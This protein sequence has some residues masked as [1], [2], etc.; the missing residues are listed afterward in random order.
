MARANAL[1]NQLGLHYGI[2]NFWISCIVQ[3]GLLQ[4]ALL[5]TALGAFLTK[6]LR[7]ADR[8]AFAILAL[9]MVIAAS[10]VSF[11][12]KNIQLAQFIILITV[13]LPRAAKAPVAVQ[14][15]REPRRFQALHSTHLVGKTP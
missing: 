10:S 13:L 5:T 6:V 12:S 8:A 3:Y 2:E 14:V 9:M 1:Q 7:N 11:S 15:Q 4:T